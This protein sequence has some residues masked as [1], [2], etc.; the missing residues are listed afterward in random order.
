[1]VQEGTFRADL[2]ARLAGHRV[3]LPPLRARREDTGLLVAA[4]LGDAFPMGETP[5]PPPQASPGREGAVSLTPRAARAIL[6]HG[7][8]G[9]VRELEKCLTTALVLAG[10]GRVDLDHLPEPVRRSLDDAVVAKQEEDEGRT[11]ELLSLMR[12]HGGN[13]TAV[14]RA[15]G[16]ARVQVQR[17]LKRYGIDA[18]RASTQYGQ[19]PAQL[20]WRQSVIFPNAGS[21]IGK[22][23]AHS[24]RQALP[25]S[26]PLGGGQFCWQLT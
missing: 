15:M 12:E 22:L 20:A 8:P 11:Q 25:P 3:E 23:I 21:A 9:N 10:D 16:K 26:T 1:M 18:V 6:R 5:K 17:W 4:L 19:A 14:A 13:V 2:L 7:W 24:D